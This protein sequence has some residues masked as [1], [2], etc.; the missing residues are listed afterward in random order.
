MYQ[1]YN[2]DLFNNISFY[3]C[4]NSSIEHP[5]TLSKIRLERYF[6]FLRSQVKC[7]KNLLY[8]ILFHFPENVPFVKEALSRVTLKT[9]RIKQTDLLVISIHSVCVSLHLESQI[10]ILLPSLNLKTIKRIS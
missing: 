7:P 9:I 6:L 4:L 10:G 3:C 2:S 1:S 8:K 5:M